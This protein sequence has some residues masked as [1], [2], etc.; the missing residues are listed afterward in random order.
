VKKQ[1]RGNKKSKMN[2]TL[3]LLIFSDIF[4]LTGYSLISPILAIFFKEGLG[5]AVVS[6]GIVSAITI[7]IR[8]ALQLLFAQ[9]AR[10]KDRFWMVIAG[11]FLLVLV[12]IVY[13]LAKNMTWIYFAAVIQGLGGG[14]AN[15]TWFSLFAANLS[16]NARG[17]EWSIYSSS[18][19]AGSAIAAVSGSML[20]GKIGF[21]PVFI[22]MTCFAFVGWLILFGLSKAE[23]EKDRANMKIVSGKTK[24]H[25]H[26]HH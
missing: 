6:I 25:N 16:K 24:L 18:V 15:P 9:I 3:K 20:A 13:I 7:F 5:A 23:R 19:G 17:W 22:I 11:G 4:V 2:K 21:V 26:N 10:P 1:K 12:P 14:L 8:C